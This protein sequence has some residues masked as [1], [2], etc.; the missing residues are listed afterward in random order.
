MTKTENNIPVNPLPNSGHIKDTPKKGSIRFKTYIISMPKVA[1][2][3]PNLKF[4]VAA[5]SLL[6][7]KKSKAA[8]IPKVNAI[9]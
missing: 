8:N 5:M 6:L 4:S 3:T 2:N 1:E 7:Y 9:A